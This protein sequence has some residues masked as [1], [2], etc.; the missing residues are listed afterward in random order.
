MKTFSQLEPFKKILYARTEDGKPITE[1]DVLMQINKKIENLFGKG[2]KVVLTSK[3][4]KSI[5]NK[6]I[7]NTLD[8][9]FEI[10]DEF[11]ITECIDNG[12]S[13]YHISL[14]GIELDEDKFGFPSYFNTYYFTPASSARNVLQ[15][16]GYKFDREGK[17]IK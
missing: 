10:G 6:V 15:G 7:S 11:L 4:P 16:M 14:N 9:D 2:K 8:S 3:L 1:Y 13:N 17:I 12:G 5:L